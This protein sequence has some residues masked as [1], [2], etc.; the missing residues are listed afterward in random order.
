MLASMVDIEIAVEGGGDEVDRVAG[1]A[2][3]ELLVVRGPGFIVVIGDVGV[4]VI[5]EAAG[6]GVDDGGPECEVGMVI[7]SSFEGEA[8]GSRRDEF[9]CECKGEPG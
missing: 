4:G 5:V 3:I 9:E 8:S 7:G 6:G 1:T 2:V